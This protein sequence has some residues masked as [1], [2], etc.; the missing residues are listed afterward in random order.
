MQATLQAVRDNLY[1]L[2]AKNL[3][4][5]TFDMTSWEEVRDM[6]QGRGGFARTSGAASSSAS[7]P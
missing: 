5:N 7:L 3:E 2:A 1:D 4:D 6:A